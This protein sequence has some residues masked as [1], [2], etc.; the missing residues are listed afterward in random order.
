MKYL[1]YTIGAEAITARANF[2]LDDNG[3]LIGYGD[4]I[5]ISEPEITCYSVEDVD[6]D[7]IDWVDTIEQAK[8]YIESLVEG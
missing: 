5:D 1:G 8:Q 3:N 7:I 2:E 6:G 4:L